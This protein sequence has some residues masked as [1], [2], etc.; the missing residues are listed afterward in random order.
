[1]LQESFFAEEM[2]C[3][4][5]VTEERK[6]LWGVLLDILEKTIDLCDRH[7][8]RY[9]VIF[10]TL[11]GA[12]RH[13]GFIPWDDDVDIAMPREDYVR[14][15]QIAS[16]ELK[17]PYFFQTTLN[18]QGYYRYPA[19]VRRSNTTCMFARESKKRYN[20]GIFVSIFPLDGVPKAAFARKR[21]DALALFYHKML[22]HRL[23]RPFSHYRA[24]GKLFHMFVIPYCKLFGYKHLFRRIN[25]L[26]AKYKW[27]E[28]DQIMIA[29]PLC[30][31][32]TIWQRE[33][34]DAVIQLDFENLKV[35]APAGYH[36]NLTT[37]YEKTFGADYMEFPPANKRGRFMHSHILDTQKPYT[38]YWRDCA[39]KRSF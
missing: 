20:Q 38:E 37:T 6:R 17:P 23:D 24:L 14:F 8:L 32:Q 12:V 19:R 7:N 16:R 10:G 21:Q 11:L 36:R 13:K 22:K 15:A 31:D 39:C 28:S 35:T 27:D 33:D 30:R 29:P 34:F 1:M 2:Q 18:E 9:Y 4:F 5:L 26:Y 3:G 25:R